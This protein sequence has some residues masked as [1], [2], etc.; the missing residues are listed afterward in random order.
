MVGLSAV[1]GRIR[2][3]GGIKG[4]KMGGREHKLV[5]YADDLMI[6]L[7]DPKISLPPLMGELERFERT[8][9]FKI[10]H[11]KSSIL[12]ITLHKVNQTYLE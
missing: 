9:G 4:L 8:A 3:N 10:N 2:L 5:L 6:V 1:G 7:T 11:T 12:S